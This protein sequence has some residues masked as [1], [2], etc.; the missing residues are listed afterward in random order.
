MRFSVED[1]VRTF[2]NKFPE[3]TLRT[4]LAWAD[5]EHYHVRRLCSEGTRPR[6]PWSRKVVV[7]MTTA[8]SIL[9]KLFFDP[10]R[11]VTR[12][13]AN[14]INDISK[15]D[16]DLAIDT[17]ARWRHSGRQD[18]SE[19]EFL[20]RH[21]TRSLVRDGHPRAMGL[22]G[23]TSQPRLDVFNV[24]VPAQVALHTAPD[25]SFDVRVHK[26]S[27]VIVDYVIRFQGKEG[28]LSGRKVFKL[29]RL[30][31]AKGDQVTLSKRHVLR[32]AMTTR[33]IYP[34][35]HQL[36]VRINGH[37]YAVRPFRII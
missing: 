34:G 22:L 11:F 10:T 1:A 3:E 27:D 6:L 37:S 19:M 17:L 35:M 12:S 28:K 31:L 8:I 18:P 5:D 32:S 15:A 33:R 26:D 36:E 4:L 25:F 30:S 16:P 23:V 14:H 21:G 7:P 9:D 29:R 2:I 13:V 24:K 20:V